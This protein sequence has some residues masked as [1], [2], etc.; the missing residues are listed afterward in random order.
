MACEIYI[1]GS[2][3]DKGEMG[4]KIQCIATTERNI[5]IIIGESTD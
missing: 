1:T 3:Y 2:L 4:Y 5:H